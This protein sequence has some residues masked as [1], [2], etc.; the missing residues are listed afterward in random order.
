[1]TSFNPVLKI[2]DQ[3]NE[4]IKMH[5][6]ENLVKIDELLSKVHLPS[7]I[8][9]SYPHEMSGGQLQRCMIAMA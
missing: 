9:N 3:I 5:K 8:K 1:M 2:K 7:R 4:S 6:K